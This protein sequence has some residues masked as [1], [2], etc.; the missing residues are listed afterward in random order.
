MA[1]F[2]DCV[3]PADIQTND[4]D[5]TINSVKGYFDACNHTPYTA[6]YEI[7]TKCHKLRDTVL[8]R[9]CYLV[10]Q[11]AWF[12]NS[13]HFGRHQHITY[14]NHYAETR[15][16]LPENEYKHDLSYLHKKYKQVDEN[17]IKGVYGFSMVEQWY[18]FIL[19]LLANEL[20]LPTNNFKVTETRHRIYNPL[21]KCSRMLRPLTPFKVVECDIKSAFPSFID[22]VINADKGK[23]IYTNLQ[24]NHNITR[25]KAK[26][27]FNKWCNSGKYKTVAQTKEFL[28]SCGYTLEECHTITGLTHSKE[29]AFVDFMCEYE[30]RYINSFLQDNKHLNGARL[31]DAVLYI[32]KNEKPFKMVYDIKC[33]FGIKN[34]NKPI[35]TTSFSYSDKCMRYAHVSSLPPASNEA[36]KNLIRKRE[37]DKHKPIGSANGFIFYAGKYEFITASF[38]LNQKYTF[39]EFVYNCIEMVNTLYFLN[40]K[41]ISKLQLYLILNHIRIN[42]NIIFNVRWLFKKLL[43]QLNQINDITIKARDF[44]FIE[45][46]TFKRKIDFLKALN[47]ARG[48]VNKKRR[49][50]N[51]FHVLENRISKNDYSFIDYKVNGKAKTNQLLKAIVLIINK[52]TTGKTRN[53]YAQSIKTNPLYSIIYKEGH[54]YSFEHHKKANKLRL[55]Q[56]KIQVYEKELIRINRLI[57]N[58]NI[59]KQ[60]LL[61]LSEV[62][63]TQTDIN[64]NR[65]VNIIEEEKAHLM[66]RLTG[67]EYKTIKQGAKAFNKI[68]LPAKEVKVKRHTPTLEDFETSLEH[69]AFNIDIEEAYNRGDQFFYEYLKFNKLDEK[70]KEVKE[71]KKKNIIV[72][73]EFD[74][75]A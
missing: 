3:F 15:N 53:T 41:P 51:L 72:L 22:F 44:D 75:D 36:Y 57:N 40:G 46:K 31:H 16:K 1:Y 33:V 70:Q 52:L 68:Y 9:A 20:K 48:E 11:S 10:V 6:I 32:D 71:V 27:L 67:S 39:D 19:F 37:Y 25:S 42:S 74:F 23:N 29:F 34:L 69:S 66:E 55:V 24:N 13:E 17:N 7:D 14:V 47:T 49:L 18:N 4:N 54:S 56:R 26:I 12:F 61:I 45:H 50:T 60:Y 21:V 30:E 73:P 64:I 59:V 2:F 65:E 62:T 28:L 38:D 35:Y 58:R 43:S 63:G 8:F 5:F